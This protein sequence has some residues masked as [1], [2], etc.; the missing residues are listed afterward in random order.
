MG[1]CEVAGVVGVLA[2][3][4]RDAGNEEPRGGRFKNECATEMYASPMSRVQRPKSKRRPR[5]APA[6]AG[7]SA[8]RPI[9]QR[10]SARWDTAPYQGRR[11]GRVRSGKVGYGRIKSLMIFDLRMTIYD[12]KDVDQPSPGYGSARRRNFFRLFP[13]FPHSSAFRGSFFIRKGRRRAGTARPTRVLTACVP[14][15]YPLPSKWASQP[16]KHNLYER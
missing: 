14:G 13:P 5:M 16:P 6:F 12:F 1:V 15:P 7:P 3:K 9:S 11:I 10:E 8:G 4:S 2:T